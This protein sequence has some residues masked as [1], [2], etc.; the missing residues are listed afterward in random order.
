MEKRIIR[1]VL[2]IYLVSNKWLH[3]S[4]VVLYAFLK[5]RFVSHYSIYWRLSS[6]EALLHGFIS[7]VSNHRVYS[8]HISGGNIFESGIYIA[9]KH[10]NCFYAQKTR[11]SKQKTREYT[12]IALIFLFSEGGEMEILIQLEIIYFLNF[13]KKQISLGG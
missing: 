1:D 5:K 8:S 7:G 12:Y 4:N 6:N 9:L 10:C 2:W 13:C 3:V 11:T